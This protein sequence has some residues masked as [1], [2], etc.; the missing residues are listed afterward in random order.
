M[1]SFDKAKSLEEI[2]L[3]EGMAKHLRGELDKCEEYGFVDKI[4]C[5]IG[6]GFDKEA[7]EPL[8]SL[9]VDDGSNMRKN[10]EA[11]FNRNIRFVGVATSLLSF[12]S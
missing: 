7:F 4:S 10:R 3:T 5:L 8:M 1:Q 9:L 2:K 12:K 6:V 11:L